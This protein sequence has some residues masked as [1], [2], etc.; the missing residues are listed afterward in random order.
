MSTFKRVDEAP[1]KLEKNEMVI[2][3]PDF[4]QEIDATR[5]RRGISKRTT[6][7]SL[8]DLF[9]A[10]TNKYDPALNPYT[11]KLSKYEGLT[12]ENDDDIRAV[13]SKIISDH[14]MP[15]VEKVIEYNIKNRNPKVDTIFY[16]SND[17]SGLGAFIKMGFNQQ[18]AEKKVKVKE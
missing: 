9:M 3:K 15:L 10:I 12:A 14:D 7:S 8:R 6:A 1:A 16:V 17:L 11:L 13:I 2:F 18:E 5:P 4:Q